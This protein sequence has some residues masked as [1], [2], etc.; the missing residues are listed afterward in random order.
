MPGAAGRNF[1]GKK[2]IK[3]KTRDRNENPPKKL[4]QDQSFGVTFIMFFKE[5]IEVTGG[6]PNTTQMY[7]EKEMTCGAVGRCF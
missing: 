5:I 7:A 2:G 1:E 6:I 3:L 4:R